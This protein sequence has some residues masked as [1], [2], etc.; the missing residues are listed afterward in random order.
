MNDERSRKRGGCLTRCVLLIVLALILAAGWGVHLWFSKP[1]YWQ[2]YQADDPVL[3]QQGESIE[4]RLPSELSKVRPLGEPWKIEISQEEVNGWIATRLPK[5]LANRRDMMRQHNLPSRL[6]E[7]IQQIMVAIEPAFLALAADIEAEDVNQVI[8]MEFKSFD[9]PN[10]L[11]RIEMTAMRGGRLWL[12]EGLVE[13]VVQQFGSTEQAEEKLLQKFREKLRQ[14]DLAYPADEHRVVEVMKVEMN[15]GTLTATCRTV[16][17]KDAVA[18]TPW[19]KRDE[20][21]EAE[22]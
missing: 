8:S 16:L 2:T 10:G 17:R 15:Q 12:P 19:I 18:E 22:Q 21:K 6:P 3:I 9:G 7:E 14:T 20:E 4:K 1:A 13:K 11:A 5:W